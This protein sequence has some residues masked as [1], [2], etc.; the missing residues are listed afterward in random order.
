MLERTRTSEGFKLWWLL[1]RARE[2][3]ARARRKEL[4][5]AGI[6]NREAA[7]L[8]LIDVLGPK[9]TIGRISYLAFREHHSISAHI[10]RMEKDGLVRKV[11]SS[12]GRSIQVLMTEKGVDAHTYALK[13]ISVHDIMSVLSE[14]EKQQLF[15]IL[16]KLRDKALGRLK[17]ATKSIKQHFLLDN[18]PKTWYNYSIE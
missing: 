5:P 14:E 11:K 15:S 3:M 8:W 18:G 12:D 2:S 16:H 13:R 1:F 4:E 17:Y 9:A 10:S 6:S 7:I